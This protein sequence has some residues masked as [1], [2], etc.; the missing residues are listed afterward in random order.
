[1]SRADSQEPFLPPEEEAELL[2][3][4]EAALRPSELDPRTQERLLAQALDDPFAPPSEA[5]LVES[6]QLREALE[7]GA[8]HPDA[9]V[10]RALGA[11]FTDAG[12]DVVERALLAAEPAPERL[13]AA[14][15]RN[16]VYVVFGAA[17]AALAAA[18]AVFL[19]VGSVQKPEPTATAAAAPQWSRPRSTT[20]LF[21]ERFETN[22]TT[23]RMD[24]IASAR[25]R[26]LRDNRYAAWGVR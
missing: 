25:S 12:Q 18:A 1:M 21:D 10:L 14:P 7:S 20:D 2:A 6:A 13:T 3:Q 26:D 15:P 19:F 11:P 24:R 4:L 17:S 23:A 22:G 9:D 5:E 8:P 16:V